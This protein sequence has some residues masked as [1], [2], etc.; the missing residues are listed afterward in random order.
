VKQRA[1][2]LGILGGGQLARMLALAAAPLGL[3]CHIFSQNPDDPGAQVTSKWF[4]GGLND[5][6]ALAAFAKT[7]DILTFESEFVNTEILKVALNNQKIQIF[8]S[9]KVLKTLQDRAT[10]K[11]VLNKFKVATTPFL[12]IDSDQDLDAAYQ[13]FRGNFVL[14]LRRNGYD[15]NGTFYCKKP[16]DL[17]IFKGL[18]AQHKCGFI[19]EGFVRFKRECALMVF[20]SADGSFAHFPLVETVQKDSRCDWVIGPESH[21]Q[22]PKL[23]S[24]LKRMMSGLKYVGALGVELFDD[25]HHLLVNE[26]APRVHNSGHYSQ[27]GLTE[28][29]FALQLRAGLGE[30][31]PSVQPVMAAFGMV[32]LIGSGEKLAQLSLRSV[33]KSNLHWYG[34][35]KNRK[36]RKMGHLNLVGEN[37]KDVLRCLLKERKG[38]RL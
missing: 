37:K 34:K 30:K 23:L 8:P 14:K 5:P 22:L 6:K 1:H 25:G 28:D 15:G 17:K 36:G 18:L 19:A 7:I 21:P 27:D 16:S 35:S 13:L 4:K 31:L 20:R 12:I 33:R 32:N 24:R 26:L 38:I 29:Q 10:Q 3:E 11:Q 2:R 9:L